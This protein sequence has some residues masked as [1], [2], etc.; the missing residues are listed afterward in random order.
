MVPSAVATG[1]FHVNNPFEIR[2]I[3]GGFVKSDV[4]NEGGCAFVPA[5]GTFRPVDTVVDDWMGA[6]IL[7]RSPSA[8]SGGTGQGYP[9]VDF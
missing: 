2:T 5:N 6:T 1:A 9:T 7:R 4:T 8:G 3:V